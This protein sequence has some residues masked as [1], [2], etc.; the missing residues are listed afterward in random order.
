MNS[1]NGTYV[2]SVRLGKQQQM[3][4]NDGDIIQFGKYPI[5][6]TFYTDTRKAYQKK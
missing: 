6:Y 1:V 5:L 3:E 4:I 2:N